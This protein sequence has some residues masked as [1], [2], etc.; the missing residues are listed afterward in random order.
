MFR[1][2]HTRLRRKGLQKPPCASAQA[3]RT[4]LMRAFND[5]ARAFK[6][7]SVREVELQHI[8]G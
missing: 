2:A 7:R 8:E 4:D 6:V 3:A 5:F 1:E